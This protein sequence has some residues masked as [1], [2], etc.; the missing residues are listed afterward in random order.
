MEMSSKPLML[1]SLLALA[2]AACGGDKAK[3]DVAAKAK[4]ANEPV[5]P[6][7]YRDQQVKFADSVLNLAAP[8]ND[9][10]KKLGVGYALAS[11]RLRDTLALLASKS[12]CFKSARS[13]D[14]YVAGTV[15]FT[16]HI[17]EVGSD[18]IQVQMSKWTSPAGNIADACLNQKSKEWKFDITFGKPATYV[19]QVQ[20]R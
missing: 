10:V 12:E 14:P 8:V 9:V 4:A 15:D 20:F 3:D 5:S 17:S 11:V 19:A 13:V 18:A 1:L 6:T 16:V 2:L 7:Q